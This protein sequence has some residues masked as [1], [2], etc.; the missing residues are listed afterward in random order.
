METICNEREID[1]FILESMP[2]D[3]S[4]MTAADILAGGNECYFVFEKKGGFRM[5][6]FS[7]IAAG[8]WKNG[9][10]ALPHEETTVDIKYALDG[11]LLK[12]DLGE[13]EMTFK[14]SDEKPPAPKES[15]GGKTAE[16]AVHCNGRNGKMTAICP[17]GWYDHTRDDTTD[18]ITFKVSSDP[19][20]GELP[21]V[22]LHC[23]AKLLDGPHSVLR[24]GKSVSFTINCRTWNGVYDANKSELELFTIIDNSIVDIVCVGIEPES[25]IVQQVLSSFNLIWE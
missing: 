16:I 8:K 9:A 17:G 7:K 3:G 5:N 13:G 11:A 18:M 14:R 12:I 22:I 4:G 25:D 15:A 23:Y 20:D 19:Y 21:S 10:I 6:L 2:D 1:Y 24:E